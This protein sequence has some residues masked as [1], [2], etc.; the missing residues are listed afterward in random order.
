M[1]EV[2]QPTNYGGVQVKLQPMPDL[3]QRTYNRIHRLTNGGFTEPSMLNGLGIERNSQLAV[4]FLW[5]S[6]FILHWDR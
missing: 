5:A 3:E 1:R 6:Y 2:N 4:V